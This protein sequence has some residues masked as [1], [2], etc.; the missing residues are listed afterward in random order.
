MYTVPSTGAWGQ[1]TV[2]IEASD[3][4]ASA[5]HSLELGYRFG[6]IPIIDAIYPS[7]APCYDETALSQT[8]TS[9]TSSSLTIHGRN[10]GRPGSQSLSCSFGSIVTNAT[11]ISATLAR[12]PI[13]SEGTTPGL[14]SFS[15]IN[16][17]GYSSNHVQ[18]R[19]IE[20]IKVSMLSPSLGYL[21]GGTALVITGM[22]LCIY[23]YVSF[24]L[25]LT[26]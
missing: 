16:D 4:Q 6:A 1:A 23:I 13:P 7:L 5:T 17:V 25:D 21:S 24:D 14:S 22:Y 3:G 12:C 9:L 10:W 11:I 19:F 15:L 8:T 26:D 20:P 18:F 2:D